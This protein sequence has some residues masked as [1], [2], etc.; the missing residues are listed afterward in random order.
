MNLPT[1]MYN[2]MDTPDIFTNIIPFCNIETISRLTRV[3]HMCYSVIGENPVY[4]EFA[5]CRNK[6]NFVYACKCNFIHVAKYLYEKGQSDRRQ[7]DECFSYACYQGYLYNA[8]WLYEIGAR[9]NDYRPFLAACRYGYL[10]MAMWLY[11]IGDVD[12]HVTDDYAFK[13]ACASDHVLVAQWLIHFG[14]GVN[15]GRWAGS[16]FLNAWIGSRFGII[17][18][19]YGY[20]AHDLDII[21]D[22]FECVCRNER[23]EIAQWLYNFGRIDV[24][25]NDECILRRAC[26]SGNSRFVEW[27]T[28][29]CD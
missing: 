7:R 3:N 25:K 29:I 5:E 26:N 27:L 18:L 4:R 28:S 19:L 1:Q 10:R 15:A 21:E 2:H 23:L 14:L 13:E 9:P 8:Q 24:H 17:K 12:I 16:E 20:V 22:G 11:D 6:F